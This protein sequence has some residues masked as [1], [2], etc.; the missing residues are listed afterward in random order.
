MMKKILL[1]SGLCYGLILTFIPASWAVCPEGN[2]TAK[3]WNPGISTSGP[4]SYT[5]AVTIKTI[6]EV[7]QISWVIGSQ[8]FGGVGFYDAPTQTLNIG[9]SDI[10]AKW[11]GL[12]SY[13]D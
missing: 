4:E 10:R 1:T 2:Y 6:D 11:F 13:K 9:Y 7:C 3:G 5:G 12:V 8:R